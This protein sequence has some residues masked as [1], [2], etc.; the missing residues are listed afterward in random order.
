[1]NPST[2][3]TNWGYAR[4]TGTISHDLSRIDW[5]NGSFWLR[6]PAGS[7]TTSYTSVSSAG[8][9][10]ATARVATPP[11]PTYRYLEGTRGTRAPIDYLDTWTALRN[12]GTSGWTC[13]SFKNTSSET[14]TRIRWALQL[15]NQNDQVVDTGYLDRK[16]TF[17]PNVEIHAWH[18]VAEWASGQ[19][20][21]DYGNGCTAWAPDNEAQRLA[22]PYVRSYDVRVSLIVY[23]DGTTWPS[24]S[25]SYRFLQR[26]GTEAPGAPIDVVDAFT[27]INRDG[28]E[29]WTC[30]SFKNASS[31]TATR[32]LF[33][34]SLLN[35]D[36]QAVDTGHLD[37]KGTFLPNVLIPGKTIAQWW[38]YEG[39]PDSS[40]NCTMWRPD[41]EAQRSEYPHAQFYSI[42]VERAGFA[43]GTTWPSRLESPAPS[44]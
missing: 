6:A 4:I 37:R 33:A 19:G 16:G 27:G 25:E 1:M 36:G 14:A 10:V 21:R 22:Y 38:V 34:L 9:Y 15:M 32:V 5:S 24:L 8:S 41:N 39:A 29:G 3:E 31:V 20:H 30:I 44:P 40:K 26:T 42:R 17:S 11:P 18:S 23:A 12:D 35:Q 28:S 7:F 2:L 13:I 43:D